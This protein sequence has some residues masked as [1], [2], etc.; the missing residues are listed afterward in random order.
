[1]KKKLFLSLLLA[2]LLL[3][4]LGM[5]AHAE[6][7]IDYVTDTAGLLSAEEQSA[8][9]EQARQIAAATGCGVYVVTVD[10]YTKYVSGNI[11]DFSEAI[12][13]TYDLGEG[14]GKDGIL[15]ALSMSER[16]YDLCAYGDF[17]NY[18]FTDY[19][20]DQLAGTFLDNFRRNDWAGGFRDYIAN[21]AALIQRAKAGNPLDT[22]VYETEPGPRITPFS[23]VVVIG[24]PLLIASM[25]VGGFKKQMKTAVRQTEAYDYI[26]QGGAR[27]RGQR[28]QFINRSVT[29]QVI[30][31][32]PVSSGRPGGHAGGTHV[33]S[34]GF[35]H[36]S[37]KF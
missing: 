21:A 5:S 32:E 17:A 18:A 30:R 34:G 9:N 28:D 27:L 4:S 29:R 3:L 14:E 12:Y 13:K 35:S 36:H 24:L 6:A 2:V 20:K 26:G 23:V 31:R 37:G 11:E 16:D 33:N 19:G 7:Q 22:Y 10:D 8:L 1:M 25:V 15:L